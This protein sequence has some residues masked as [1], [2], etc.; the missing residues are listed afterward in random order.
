MKE[1]APKPSLPRLPR[2]PFRKIVARAVADAAYAAKLRDVLALALQGDKAAQELLV[3]KIVLQPKDLRAMGV[4]PD[5]A[6]F[7]G[8]VFPKPIRCN[9]PRTITETI[10]LHTFAAHLH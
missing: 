2:L 1:T 9:N 8:I 3:G 4:D 10:W 7:K 5:D 6:E